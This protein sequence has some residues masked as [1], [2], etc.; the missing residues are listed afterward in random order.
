M[1]MF[2]SSDES[3]FDSEFPM[4]FCIQCG[5]AF[6]N[7]FERN[8]NAAHRIQCETPDNILYKELYN[9]LKK[10]PSLN[11]TDY[12]TVRFPIKFTQ[13]LQPNDQHGYKKIIFPQR[14]DVMIHVKKTKKKD[15]IK[16][17]LQCSK[18]S[19]F[20]KFSCDPCV[21]VI[22]VAKV[23]QKLIEIIEQLQDRSI[24]KCACHRNQEKECIIC[25][26]NYVTIYTAPCS[27]AVMCLHCSS[28]WLAKHNECPICRTPVL[29]RINL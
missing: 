18:C 19:S 8:I 11:H 22:T 27:H 5:R 1:G 28:N 12:V 4:N 10:E 7:Y 29:K 21:Y 14:D 23:E 17:T 13:I 24:P 16:I 26:D 15:K 3:C 9:H 6:D 20:D 25:C 2:I